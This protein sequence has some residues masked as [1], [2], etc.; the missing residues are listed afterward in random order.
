MPGKGKRDDEKSNA[1]N[2]SENISLNTKKRKLYLIKGAKGN[3][4]FPK[5]RSGR[6]QRF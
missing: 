5:Y 3:R 4:V 2:T 1:S 6:L